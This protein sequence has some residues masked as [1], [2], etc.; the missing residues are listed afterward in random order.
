MAYLIEAGERCGL[1]G[2]AGWEWE[3]DKRAYNPVEHFCQGCY[4]K[5]L[6]EDIAGAVAGTTIRLTSSRSVESARRIISQRKEV[7]RGRRNA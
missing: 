4:S 5:S 7:T 6:L 1:C 2:T 3:E